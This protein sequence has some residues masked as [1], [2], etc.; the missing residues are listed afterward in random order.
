MEQIF[1]QQEYKKY[2]KEDFKVWS[3]LFERQMKNLPEKA[4][5]EFLKGMD[6]VEFKKEKI[7][8]FDEVNKKLRQL[9]GWEL[10]AVP[11]IVPDKIFFELLYTKK[12]P[13]T[14]W[15]RKMSQLDYLEEPD[16]FHDVFAHVPLLSNQPFCDF[17]QGLSI[18]ALKHID[19]D[20]AIELVSRIYWFTVE[21]GLINEEGNLRIYGA[22]ILSSNGET[23]FCLSDEPPKHV[24]DVAEIL[25]SPYIKEKFQEKYF[26][27]DSYE[28]LFHSLDQFERALEK[29]LALSK[30]S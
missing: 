6:K 21:F 15:L 27:I 9:T 1:I 28:N 7:P 25:N 23:D 17:L 20:W 19:N 30:E 26:V 29:M 16:M 13:A 12:F 8:N 10:Q 14:T 11:G 18:I 24:F 3:I 22:G 2:S 4:T 5:A